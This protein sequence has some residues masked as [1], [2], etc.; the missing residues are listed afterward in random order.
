MDQAYKNCKLKPTVFLSY[1]RRDFNFCLRLSN[2]LEA[3][4]YSTVYDKSSNVHDDLDLRL[5]AQDEWWVTLKSMISASEAMVFIVT[6]N[7]AASAASAASAVCDDEIAHARA[8]GKRVIPILRESIEFMTAPERLRSLNVSIDFRNDTL[9][10]FE[11]AVKEL[12]KELDFD[13]EWH[14]MGARFMRQ[15]SL[16]DKQGRPEAQLLTAGAVGEVDAW[17]S[18]RPINA[19]ALGP[20]LLEHLDAS[21][22]SQLRQRRNLLSAVGA[23]YV[24]PVSSASQEGRHDYALRLLALGA[25]RS[26]D[27]DFKFTPELWQVGARAILSNRLLSRIRPVAEP[28]TVDVTRIGG[29]SISEDGLLI[30]HFSAEGKLGVWNTLD[31]RCVW[32][33]DPFNEIAHTAFT[34]Q[35]TQWYTFCFPRGAYSKST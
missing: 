9:A 19:P 6:P 7:S 20:L 8:L 33:S 31:G 17:A 4:G 21:R 3:R 13:V 32:Q 27:F 26:E 15:A 2:A 11:T 30:A 35:E 24:M 25:M 5:T 28:N 14:R 16:W 29:T 12:C 34:F 18:R 10:T 23:G 1:S 22:A